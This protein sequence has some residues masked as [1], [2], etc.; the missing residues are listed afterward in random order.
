MPQQGQR[1]LT[2]AGMGFISQGLKHGRQIRGRW[3][4]ALRQDLPEGRDGALVV[5]LEQRL[6]GRGLQFRRGLTIADAEALED[7]QGGVA[8]G[9]TQGVDRIETDRQGEGGVGGSGGSSRHLGCRYLRALLARHH[10]GAGGSVGSLCDRRHEIA[11]PRASRR[12]AALAPEGPQTIENA[13]VAAA[14]QPQGR[15]LAYHRILGRVLNRVP[16]GESLAVPTGI[17]LGQ[18]VG[19]RR[20][21]RAGGPALRA[22]RRRVSSGRR[23][24]V[25]VRL[26]IGRVGSAGTGSQPP[27]AQSRQKQAAGSASQDRFAGS[28][29]CHDRIWPKAFPASARIPARWLV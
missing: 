5:G 19:D 16:E 11:D 29:R 17:A 18:R 2:G 27:Q 20:G 6:E 21:A 12:Q 14:G 28:Q 9:S 25:W 15:R 1:N 22:P 4:R 13:A 26:P 8:L 7:S 24:G 3:R 23:G 10:Q